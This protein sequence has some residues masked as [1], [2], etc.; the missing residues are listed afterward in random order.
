MS[1]LLVPARF[2]GPP[3]VVNGGYACASVAAAL[4][5]IAEVTLRR[6]VPVATPLRL[7]RDGDR[8]SLLA[9][10]GTLLAEGG[11]GAPLPDAPAAP[12][13]EVAEAAMAGGITRNASEFSFPC[14][15]C[16]PTRDD[17]FRMTPG[18]IENGT[19]VGATWTPAAEC[20]GE[21]GAV[22]A[23]FVWAVLDCTGSIGAMH[24]HR[25]PRGVLLGRMRACIDAPLAPG[26]RYLARGWAG[27]AEGRKL[28]AGAALYDEA[29][30]AVARAA[31]LTFAPK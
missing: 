26:Q 14:F 4:D 18:P 23:R 21:D 30:R 31:L 1:E 16:H 3:E 2:T 8:A 27:A 24:A 12:A 20:A 22:D 19:A 28:P 11:P 5:G 29:G 17:G 15:V 13:D 6:P 9:P 7:E 10:D 25:E